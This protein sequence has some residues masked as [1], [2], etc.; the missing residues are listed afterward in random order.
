MKGEGGSPWK[1][2]RLVLW[3]QRE[4]N[5]GENVTCMGEMLHGSQRSG[6]E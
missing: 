2:A 3:S 5:I 6:S 4:E 1:R